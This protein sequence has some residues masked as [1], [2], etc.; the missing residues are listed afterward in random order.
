MGTVT[1]LPSQPHRNPPYV[2]CFNVNCD[3]KRPLYGPS[4]S[5]F[6]FLGAIESS[7]CRVIV[8]SGYSYEAQIGLGF[9]EIMYNPAVAFRLDS[10]APMAF[11]A[12]CDPK[13][14]LQPLNAVPLD[15][16]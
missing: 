15:G 2:A 12:P 7:G 8:V 9:P 4:H 3:V 14:Y 11:R 16:D 5:S 13:T 10:F 1:R 6:A